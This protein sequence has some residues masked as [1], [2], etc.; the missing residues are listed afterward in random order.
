MNKYQEALESI[1]EET[2]EIDEYDTSPKSSFCYCA[3]EVEVLQELV[4]RATPKKLLY[5]GEYVS[6]CNC[7]NCKKVVPIHGNY[8]PRCGQALD[9]RIENG[10]A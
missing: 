3:E 5:N 8:C 9:W 1:K 2:T 7:P 4:E 6:F 10:K